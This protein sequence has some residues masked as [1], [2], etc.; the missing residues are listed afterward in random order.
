MQHLILVRHEQH[1]NNILSED[2]ILKCKQR[3]KKLLKELQNKNI[4]LP[5]LAI[6]SNRPRAMDTL[7]YMLEGMDLNLPISQT[8][9]E[10]GDYKSGQYPY[11]A[12]E[13][14]NAK[15]KAIAD[16]KNSEDEYEQYLLLN[17][18]EKSKLRALESLEIINEV[19]NKNKGTIILC[20]HGC[21]RLEAITILLEKKEMNNPNFFYERGGIAI[22]YFDDNLN[23][24]KV[25][26]LSK[27]ID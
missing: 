17:F 8:Y 22:V 12:E 2:I 16:G 11:T 3:G 13:V 20:S 26:H 10:L 18:P 15:Q 1:K 21:S 6:S 23:L 7:K 27:L 14:E 4:T 25:E 24:E 19:L 9:E 5:S